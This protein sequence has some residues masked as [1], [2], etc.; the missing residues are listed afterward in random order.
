LWGG[1]ALVHGVLVWLCLV[2]HGWP[3]GDVEVVYRGWADGAAAG[4]IPGVTT[5]FV[6]PILALLPISAALTFGGGFY[7]ATWLGLIVLLDAAAFQVLL[8]RRDPRAVSAAWW[9]LGFL[10]LLGPI[11]LARI[12]SVT[13]PIVI[14]ALLLVGSRPAWGTLLLVIATWVKVWPAAAIAALAVASKERRRVLAVAVGASAAIVAVALGL[15]SGAN[16]FSFVTAQTNRGIQI[17][18]PVSTVWMWLAALH[19][20]GSFLYYDQQILTFQVT[21]SGIDVGIALMTP[22]LAVMSAAVLLLGVLAHRR[23][24]AFA[25]LFPVLV[26]ALVLTLIAFNK[27]GSPQFMSWLAAPVILGLVLRGTAW[28]TPAILATV[29]AALT[30]LVYPHLYDW[31][32]AAEPPMVLVLTI[33]NLLEFVL[34][35]WAVGRLWTYAGLSRG[36]GLPAASATY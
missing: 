13:V 32:L 25:E 31:L 10:L 30:Q 14:V 6:Y 11:A 23:G 21:G 3:L 24:T 33:R 34:L 22:L 15:G 26:L 36:R 18:S 28:R 2:A 27:V 12:D 4:T 9:W 20:P 35:G 29:L 19:V 7:V 8:G 1:F 16:V 17:E 5:E